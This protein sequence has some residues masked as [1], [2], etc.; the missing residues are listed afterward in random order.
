MGGSFISTGSGASVFTRNNFRP[1]FYQHAGFRLVAPEN[2]QEAETFVTSCTGEICF[3]ERGLTRLDRI[4]W[5]FIVD[6]PCVEKSMTSTR[7]TEI[8]RE[9]CQ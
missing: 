8:Y 9:V 4:V 7:A 3:R 1:H 5:P 6:D 2:E